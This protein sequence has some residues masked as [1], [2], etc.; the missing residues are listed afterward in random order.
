MI[1]S[2]AIYGL[3][4]TICW[5]YPAFEKKFPGANERYWNAHESWKNKYKDYPEDQ[6]AKFPGAKTIFVSFTDAKHL[7]S[8]F[9]RIFLFAGVMLI[10]TGLLL[11]DW[12]WLLL[13]TIIV[14]Y[15]AHAIGFHIIYTL[16]F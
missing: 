8:E 2:G 10:Y 16:Y 1:L 13:K 12:N 9:H 15:I 14:C 11:T 7:L 3:H 5:H 6:R 4:E